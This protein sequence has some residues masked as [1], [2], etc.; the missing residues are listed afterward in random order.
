MSKC[1]HLCTNAKMFASFLFSSIG[2]LVSTMSKCLHL[3]TKHKKSNI[4][5]NKSK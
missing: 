5:N 3:C 2:L 4:N 1:L